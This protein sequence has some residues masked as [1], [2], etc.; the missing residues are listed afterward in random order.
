MGDTRRPRVV[1]FSAD[2]PKPE[3]RVSRVNQPGP[4][5]APRPLLY[6][7]DLSHSAFR[8]ACWLYDHMKPGDHIAT[9]WTVRIGEQLGM[10]DKTV[11]TAIKELKHKKIIMKVDQD[12]S[13]RGVLFNKYFMRVY[14]P[15]PLKLVKPTKPPKV[16]EFKAAKAK[17]EGFADKLKRKAAALPT[18]A[19]IRD[20]ERPE[21]ATCEACQGTGFQYDRATR[22]SRR[23][24]ACKS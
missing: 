11:R 18:P 3:E 14:D 9:G 10:S 6:R 13:H 17:A 7:T 23:C 5:E 16:S 24:P 19:P 22:A 8:V 15:N 20:A 12:T 21:T 2:S 4:F 1:R